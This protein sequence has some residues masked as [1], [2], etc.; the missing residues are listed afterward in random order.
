MPKT[1]SG[2]FAWAF[3]GL[4]VSACGPTEQAPHQVLV[5]VESEPGQPLAGAVISRAG[6]ELGAS[7]ADGIVALG[8]TGVPGEVVEL[9]TACPSGYRAPEKPLSVALRQLADRTRKPEYKVLCAPLLRSL[10]IAVRAPNAVNVP[11]R[12]LGKELAR[13]DES[14][15]A[16]ALLSVSPGEIVTVTLDTSGEEHAA[17]MPQHPELKLSMPEHDEVAV[18]DQAFTRTEPARKKRTTARRGPTR[19]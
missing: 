5:R 4:A 9:S 11:L 14:G 3:I 13:T 8:L 16:H 1:A 7:Q 6:R 10:V 2:P 15:A 12:Y 18:F 17:L 19:L